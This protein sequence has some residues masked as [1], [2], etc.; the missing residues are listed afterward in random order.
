MATLEMIPVVPGLWRIVADTNGYLLVRNGNSL[1][2]DCPSDDI[3]ELLQHANLPVPSVILHTQVQEE[4]CFDWSAFPQA[5]VFVSVESEDIARRSAQFFADCATEWPPSREWDSRGEEKY[6]V[7]GCTTE[8][9]PQMPLQVAGVVRAGECFRWEDLELEVLALPGHGKRAIGFYSRELNVVFSGDLLYAG[10]FLVNFYDLERSYGNPT[11]YVQLRESLACVTALQPALLLPTT[12]PVITDPAADIATLLTRLDALQHQPA[13][14]A[15]EQGG[16]TNYSPLR[17]FGRYREIVP[18]IF[19]NTNFGNVILFIDEQGRGFMIDPDPCVWLSWEENCRE[20]HADL[21]LLERE[22][23]LKCVEFATM[24]HFHGDHL[25]YCD[26]L[27]ARYGT[28]IL[29]APDVGALVERA[30]EFP[31]P[32]TID[33]YGFPFDHVNIDKIIPY[34]QPFLWHDVPVTPIHT[35]GHC[36]AHAG[37]HIPW[38]GMSTVCTGD[39]IQYG[40]GPIGAGLSIMYNDTAWPDR[41]QLVA[42]RHAQAKHPELVLCGH[43]QSFFD[44]DGAILRDMAAAAEACQPRIAALIH[45]GDTLRAMTPPGFDA[46]RPALEITQVS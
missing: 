28:V 24:T 18:G 16:T 12:G 25:E 44:R 3:C 8:R 37:F 43:S 34:D 27:R 13:L 1:L 42:I 5:D 32:C 30:S 38:R 41:G 31:Y 4:H 26:L 22:A 33:W 23:G 39:T 11:G 35:P 19:Q 2:I 36:F 17:E 9:P 20:M 7:A 14:R 10:G 21:D 46:I 40:Q 29:A 45:D 15:G 6:G